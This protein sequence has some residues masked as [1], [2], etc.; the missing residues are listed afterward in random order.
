M[1]SVLWWGRFDPDYSRNRILRKL[2]PELG[3]NIV[4]FHPR[5]SP[6]ASVEARLKRLAKPDLVWVPC[7]RQRDLAAASRWARHRGIPL[8]FDP[9]ISA[10]DKQIFERKK[11]A[12]QSRQARRLHRWE[13]LLFKRSD[14]LLADTQAHADYFSEEFGIRPDRI[15]VVYVGAEASLFQPAP[16]P[17]HSDGSPVEVLFY[18]S[19]IDLQAPQIIVEATRVYNGPPVHWT[20]LGKGPLRSECERLARGLDNVHF[21]NPIPYEQLPARIHK[22]DILLGVFDAGAKAGRV[23]PNKVFQSLAC[24]RPVVTRKSNAYPPRAVNGTDAGVHWVEPG[25]PGDLARGIAQLAQRLAVESGVGRLASNLYVE[26][27]SD[28]IISGQLQQ[29]L[30]STQTLRSRCTL[31]P[32]RAD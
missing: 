25:N 12:P 24:G 30:L 9:L 28:K 22:A 17:D 26:A 13:Q 31:L 10:Y 19:F 8:L 29:V 3:W 11:C 4:D 27:F 6:L 14:I 5:F 15:K 7:F 20:L 32:S 23:I 16:M 2:L 21:E 1:P 18:G